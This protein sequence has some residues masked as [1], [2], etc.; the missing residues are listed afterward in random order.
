MLKKTLFFLF[1]FCLAQLSFSQDWKLVQSS[2]S[3]IDNVVS[4]MSVK[5]YGATG[6][7]ITEVS[8]QFQSCLDRVKQIGGGVVFVPQG[9]YVI[10]GNLIIPK[11]VTLRGE[12]S[13]P[14][15]G[16]AIQGTILMAYSGRAD[17]NAAAFITMQP[18]SAVMDLAIWY[19]DQLPGSIT[20]YPAS[21]MFG[22]TGYF[23]NDFCNAKNITFVNSYSGLVYSRVN[24]GSCPVISG[25]YGTPLSRGCEIDNIADVGRIEW[26]DFS[27]AYWAGSGLPNSPAIGGA[28]ATW[29]YENG[30]GIVMRRNDWSYTCF[31]NIEGYNKGFHVAP[32]ISSVGSIPNG[33]NYSMTFTNCKTGLYFEVVSSDGIMF[34]RVNTVNCETGIAV[35][36]NTSGVVQMHTCNIDGRS[37]AITIDAASSIKFMMQQCIIANGPVLIS[38][39]TFSATDCDFNNTVPQITLGI[40]SRAIITGNRFKNGVQIKNN[41]LY[42]C[43]INHAP[44]VSKKLPDFPV[45]TPETH[46]PTRLVLYVVTD[47]PYFAKADGTTDNTV[48]IQNALNKASA[49]GGGIVFLPPGKY[50]VLGNLTVPAGVELKGSMDIST[51]PTGPGSTLEVY[52]GKGN[53]A[54]S[55]FLK[56]AAGSGLR[57]INFNYPDQMYTMLP[58]IP[59]YPYCIQVTG[60]NVY[61]INVGIRATY[62]GIDMFSY[63]CDNH[64]LDYVAGH[65]FATGIKV[66]GNST[67]GKIYNL[68]FNVIAYGCGGESKF[69]NWPNSGTACFN[70]SDYGLMNQ[71][72]LVLGNCQNEL[73][74]NNFHFS[75]H[76]GMV[77]ASDGGTGPTGLSLG[78]GI[79]ASLKSMVFEAIGTSGFDFINTQVVSLGNQGSYIQ[80][81]PGFTSQSTLFNSD[82]WGSPTKGIVLNG[83]KIDLQLANFHN[84]GQ[85]GLATINTGSLSIQ[86]SSIFP[87][88]L[89]LNAG[90]ESKF[91]AQG[92]IVDT[93]GITQA[94]CTLWGNN[95][96]N[97]WTAS[98]AGAIDRTGWTATAS[99]NNANAGLGIDNNP[100]TRW[101]T[102][103]SQTNGQW[104]IVDMKAAKT[105]NAVILDVTASMNDFPV[106]FSTYVSTDGIN[107]GTA[108]ASGSGTTGTTLITFTM[109]TARYIKIV[110]T[111]S[112]GN[113][114]SIHEFYVLDSTS[115]ISVSGVSVSPTLATLM[116][117]ATQQLTE[118]ITPNNVTNATVSWKSSNEAVATVS[119]TG[120]VTAVTKG[121]AIITVS[122]VDGNKTATSVITVIDLTAQLN[123]LNENVFSVYPNPANESFNIEIK[124]NKSNT[125]KVTLFD[126]TGKAVLK[127]NY[128]INKLVINTEDL[129]SGIYVLQ[130]KSEKD[131]YVHKIA[132]R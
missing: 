111:G 85:T 45:I 74:Y 73:L 22:Q 31:V 25:L 10:K 68:Q 40:K 9:K 4:A 70:A 62:N 65:V 118:M 130:V 98:T 32:S 116:I 17:E 77:L 15:K 81:S 88:Q 108:V 66:G 97:A 33:H 51:M 50:K 127:E 42:L 35:G 112:A 26:I 49:D 44:V 61:I 76:R 8:A 7:G 75:S 80:T 90:A 93:S 123:V 87:T 72:F 110:Q 119:A 109:T 39:G 14:V 11:G 47:A 120:L 129:Q 117:G 23:G 106:S 5:D 52:A 101:T 100:A 57:G 63:K 46:K 37:S 96:G 105:F 113:Y 16:Q 99:N 121:T 19:P 67:G 13:K 115:P 89:I 83:G 95:L 24:G 12:W 56:L 20:S 54:G 3:T 6:D 131:L 69:G 94:N 27:P 102:G 43:A 58:D 84:P 125:Y 53:P 64:F 21:I 36:E 71:D 132:I 91:S 86:N 79:D 114:W 2:Y 92:S 30:T 124:K 34:A 60:S 29:I 82:Y 126:R 78:L 1:F 38:G 59:A 18:S 128:I 55:P 104:Y 122:T 103:T 48:S 41:S 107:W 28:Y